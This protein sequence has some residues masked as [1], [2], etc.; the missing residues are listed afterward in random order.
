M[1]TRL[2][3]LLCRAGASTGSVLLFSWLAACGTSAGGGT[4]IDPTQVDTGGSGDGSGI[5][6][7][8]GDTSGDTSADGSGT[9]D[10]SCGNGLRELGEACD[11]GNTT[12][13]DGCEADC[14]VTSGAACAPCATSA[15]CGSVAPLCGTVGAATACLA[16]CDATGG[17][18]DGFVCSPTT[19]DGV[20]RAACIPATGSC[21]AICADADGDTICDQDDIC[22]AGDDRIDADGDGTPDACEG[23]ELCTNGVDDDANGLVDCFDAACAADASCTIVSREVCANLI[24]DDRNGL[25]DCADPICATEPGCVVLTEVCGNG[26][27]DDRNGLADCADA[28]CASDPACIVISLEVCDNGIDDDGN[29]RIDCADPACSTDPGCVV[30]GP[31][32]CGNGIDDDDNGRIDCADGACATDPSCLVGAEI[33]GNGIDDDRNGSTD[34]ADSAC[35]A[36]PACAPSSEICD[37]LADNDGDR[38]IDCG[39]LDCAADPACPTGPQLCTSPNLFGPVG[40]RTG[41]T[42]SLADN[43]AGSCAVSDGPE[44]VYSFT[45]T[46]AG[47]LCART[48]GSSYDT[49]LYV[50]TACTEQNSEVACNDDATFSQQSQLAFTAVAGQQYFFF[51][52]GFTGASGSYALTLSAGACPARTRENCTD[53]RDNDFDLFTDCTDSDC[54]ADPACIVTPEDCEDGLDND[55]DTFVDCDDAECSTFPTCIPEALCDNGVDDDGDND[56]D[57]F[58]LDCLGDVACPTLEIC[59][60]SSDNDGDG[61]I[62]CDDP[63]CIATAGCAIAAQTC[64]DP[65]VSDGYGSFFGLTDTLSDNYDPT[66]ARSSAP[67]AVWRFNP[68]ATG[69]VCI[70]TIG[71]A[72]DTVLYARTTCGGREIDCNDDTLG[73][74]SEIE[75]DVTAGTPVYLFIDGFENSTGDY[76]LTIA[77][78]ACPARVETLC[79]DGLDNDGDRNIDCNDNDCNAEPACIPPPE[80]V[81]DDGRDNDGDG[82]TDCF[83]TDCAADPVCAPFAG[84][85]TIPLTLSLTG[86]NDGTIPDVGSNRTGTCGGDATPEQVWTIGAPV[87]T[88]SEI[89][90]TV[91][92]T[93]FTPILHY[94]DDTC[95]QRAGEQD[96]VNGSGSTASMTVALQ[97]GVVSYIIVDGGPGDYL[98]T[99]ARG[100]C[101]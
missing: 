65:N 26:L 30:L 47:T 84:T 94:R 21:E 79:T 12:E 59:D 88:A 32:I 29:G 62:D 67:E 85:C 38:L 71:S 86:S 83:D 64:G 100:A 70:N 80:T 49:V 36:D 22:A 54:D 75:L 6:D 50:R 7:A 8:S 15:D 16:N 10:A 53:G 101:P 27:D 77:E 81:C 74:Q 93:G 14:A 92:A 41:A 20:D 52:D 68:P 98:V 11:D 58:D 40:S 3:L 44:T 46:A 99:T 23:I 82:Q 18:S 9:V 69:T 61:L 87:T 35:A 42:S 96:C 89:C 33:C 60:D 97:P 45:A 72:F 19:V 25:T 24:D 43:Q 76:R 78:G 48:F 51:V 55:R 90:V 39:D 31:E 63:E 28:A 5:V 17:C 37:D 13:G 57:C 1:S 66:C 4:R 95:T 56:I 2:P 73:Q 34:C 91:R